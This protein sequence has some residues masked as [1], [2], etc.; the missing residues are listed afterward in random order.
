MQARPAAFRL[1]AMAVFLCLSA[2]LPA[3]LGPAPAAALEL[4]RT[5]QQAAVL[6]EALALG[7]RGD[8][9]GAEARV[10][11]EGDPLLS[12]IVLW[13]KLRAGE[14]TD[15]EYRAFVARRGGWPGQSH[16]RRAV[17][18]R[19]DGAGGAG[20]SGPAAENWRS[21]DRLYDRRRWDEAERL[22]EQITVRPENLGDPGRWSRARLVLARRAAR[23]G[24]AR[25]AYHLA[26]QHHLTPAVGYDYA[27]AEWVAG[28]VALR[29]LG[30]AQA[31]LGHFTRFEAAVETPISLGRG[32]YW[33]GRALEALGRADEAR[34]AYARAAAHQTSFYGQLAAAKIGAPGDPSLAAGDL[35]D[36][37]VSP[38][39]R[40]DDV[41][42]AT[43]LLFAGEEALAF[44]S[45]SHLGRTMPGAG[46]IAALGRLAIELDRPHYAVRIAKN[47]ARR[48]MVILP[49]YY[50]LHDLA[51]YATEV[52]PAL[53]MAVARQETELNPEAV[54]PAGA[55][56]LM[57]LMPATAQRVAGWIGEAYSAPRLT[58]D[59][60]Y[61]ARLGQRYLARRIGQFGGSYVLAAAAYNAG[62]HRVDEW[63]VEIGDP[64]RPGATVEDMIDWTEMIP[65]SETRNYVQRVIEALYV[66]RSR[67]SGAAGPM[68]V[69]ADLMRGTGRG[70]AGLE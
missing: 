8:W 14:G 16:L 69:E 34:A 26:S 33:T 19:A 13:R 4:D 56:G 70:V 28:W 51:A 10:A 22:L 40:H 25:R 3:A 27:D 6:A 48:G 61:N 18:G 64:R 54:S 60:R 30:D 65:F 47:A 32:G 21:F 62:A 36:W 52:E 44:Q 38:A 31:A 49:A 45:F 23:E 29:Q 35:P 5:R 46:A 55:R 58:E 59:W 20:L 11:A 7:A 57:Q 67:L 41:R 53:A 43:L 39:I 37:R 17:F 15:D 24:R 68:T 63:L 2:A 42:M 1:A 9:P 66:Y 12:D 50:P